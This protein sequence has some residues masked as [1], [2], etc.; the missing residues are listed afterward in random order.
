MII[1]GVETVLI[2]LLTE[3]VKSDAINLTI[4]THAEIREQLYINWFN[5]HPEIKIIIIRPLSNWFEGLKDRCHGPLKLIRKI[6]FSFYKK[7]RRLVMWL[8][9]KLAHI[10][11]LIDY[12][13]LEFHKEFK[14][15]RKPKIA[16]AHSSVEYFEK[17]NLFSRLDQYDKFVCITD[18]FVS[19]FS[20][21]YPKQ[22]HKAVRIYNPINITK[23]NELSK[24]EEC[25][26]CSYFCHVSRLVDGKDIET[27]LDAFELFVEKT[28]RKDIKLYVVGGGNKEEY[29]KNYAKQLSS[30]EQI[31]FTG[32]IQNPY[33]YMKGSL[34]NILSSEFEGLPT[35]VIESMALGVPTISSNC[36]FGP[37]EI[38][39][40]GKAGFLFEVGD[41][42]A[43]AEKMTQIV[44][45]PDIALKK[46]KQATNSLNRFEPAHIAQEISRILL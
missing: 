14:Y 21:K 45:F 25:P 34:A 32:S 10:D 20:R 42:L 26:Q 31:I 12:K 19:E 5:E 28:N 33:G 44:D 2:N 37:E 29:F 30:A 22:A 13:N 35:V 18:A 27:L 23:I 39:L 16:W 6:V 40:N 7:Y 43:L 9:R 38:L 3:L 11:I 8:S 41:K 17:N 15:F 36:K 4:V 1:G 46:V 24:L